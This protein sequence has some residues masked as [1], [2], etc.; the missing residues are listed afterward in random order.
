MNTRPSRRP[1]WL[2]NPTAWIVFIKSADPSMVLMMLKPR[3]FPCKRA[4]AVN[5]LNRVLGSEQS[6]GF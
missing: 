3:S 4:G 6:S 1:Y 2:P 5:L